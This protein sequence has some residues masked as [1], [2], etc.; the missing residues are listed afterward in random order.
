MLTQDG[1]AGPKEQVAEYPQD[2]ESVA[3]IIEVPF[4]V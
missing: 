2:E 1:T 4:V 3:V